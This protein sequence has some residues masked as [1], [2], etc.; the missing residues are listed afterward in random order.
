MVIIHTVIQAVFE[1]LLASCGSLAEENK[2]LKSE[3]DRLTKESKKLRLENALLTVP[4]IQCQSFCLLF[5][6]SF[7]SLEALVCW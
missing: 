5:G 3:R 1:E 7:F 4:P 2:T 6:C